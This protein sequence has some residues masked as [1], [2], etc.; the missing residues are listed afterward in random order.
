[1]ITR[2]RAR[3][4]AGIGAAAAI[5][6]L[7]FVAAVAA[8]TAA[9]AA[10]F[11]GVSVGVPF[12]FPFYYPPYPP[13]YYPPTRCRRRPITHRRPP[14]R[15]HHLNSRLGTTPAAAQ[16]PSI[17][18]TPRRAWTDAA[19]RQCREDKTTRELNGRP[20]T[21][22]YGTALPRPRRSMADR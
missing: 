11:V 12:G 13:P 6:V 4:V 3:P 1:M 15:R 21:Q 17:T 8:S 2:T 18:Y 10:G 20:A 16:V 19:G 22:V 7:G 5:A 9:A 14:I